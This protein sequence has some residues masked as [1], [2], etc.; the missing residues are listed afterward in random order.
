MA[1]GRALADE[2]S[3]QNSAVELIDL[4][5]LALPAPNPKFHEDPLLHSDPKIVELAK[6]INDSDALILLSPIYHNSYS[7][8]LKNAL[9]NLAIA[10]FV[11]KPMALGS[12][13]GDRT[14]QA[15]DHLRIVARGLNAIAITTNVCASEE[16]FVEIDSGYNLS[17]PNIQER[18]ERLVKELIMITTKLQG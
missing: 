5:E 6:T 18:I 16:D 9:D 7:A 3:K 8:T 13:G 17:S 15:V 2:I 10:Q 4:V 14:T 12:Q 11:G 1:L